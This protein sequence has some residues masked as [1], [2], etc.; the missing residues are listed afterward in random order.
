MATSVCG[1][2]DDDRKRDA[3]TRNPGAPVPRGQSTQA[4]QPRPA[5]DH[6]GRS[7]R[8]GDLV[9]IP[10]LV[11]AVDEGGTVNVTLET[12]YPLRP[13]LH[14]TT[15]KLSTDQ[16]ELPQSATAVEA[17]TVQAAD[18]VWKPPAI[19]PQADLSTELQGRVNDTL[20]ATI[21]PSQPMPLATFHGVFYSDSNPG[22]L[23]LAM[24]L[25]RDDAVDWIRHQQTAF[26]C[27]KD[28]FV[29][30]EV[31]MNG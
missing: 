5:L 28:D 22:D 15:L 7:V 17:G 16:V 30:R 12:A 23:P 6:N 10:A 13:G 21:I 25:D 1:S 19:L 26:G 20:T 18:I 8:V 31:K 29:V 24:F 2:S 9:V 3:R 14:T 11:T 27:S 4:N